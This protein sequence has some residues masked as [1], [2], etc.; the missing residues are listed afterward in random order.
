MEKQSFSSFSSSSSFMVTIQPQ[1]P[2]Q[3]DSHCLPDQR[4]SLRDKRLLH[5]PHWNT[6]P[7]QFQLISHSH[8]LGPQQQQFKRI[9]TT[10]HWKPLQAHSDLE[11]N[12]FEDEIPSE[13]GQI[14]ELQYLSLF[15]N[16]LN[17]TIPNQ[18]CSIKGCIYLVYEYVERGSLGKVLY[19]VNEKVELD[20][21]TRVNI[22]QGVAHAIAYL[23]HD[24]FPPIVH[25]DIIVNN[26]LLE[27]DFKPRLSDFGI[28]R[29]LDPKKINWTTIAG[30][31]GYMAP[32]LALTMQVTEKCDVYSFGVVTLEVM[33]GRHPRELLASLSSSQSTMAKLVTDNKEFLLKDV[34]DQGFPPPTGQIVEAVVFVVTVALGMVNYNPK[35]QPPSIL[36]HKN[37]HHY[38]VHQP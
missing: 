27:S 13:I 5:L 23:H 2:L 1:Q 24:C 19:G 18:L 32:E 11:T 37:C 6:C 4:N 25:R 21:G 36:W 28:A 38:Q 7:F 8:P 10:S 16:S 15:N 26:I 34:L 30:S 14:M 33:M 12:S 22:V 20:W 35:S 29:L 17:G 9:N 31:Y 3:L